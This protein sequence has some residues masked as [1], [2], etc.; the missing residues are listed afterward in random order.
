MKFNIKDLNTDE[1][2]TKSR[3]ESDDIY[4]TPSTRGDRTY[5]EVRQTNLYGLAA[6]QFLI[7]KC[8]FNNDPRSYKDVISPSGLSVEVKVTTVKKVG[9]LLSRCDIERQKP[10]RQFSD[11]LFIFESGWLSGVY[12][13]YGTYHWDGDGFINKPFDWKDE[14]NIA[15]DMSYEELWI[16][17][18]IFN[19]KHNV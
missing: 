6:E 8:G 13:L 12:E 11:W 9:A 18:P 16:Q 7:E 14:A 19:I 10:Y 15:I 2:V 4:S 17:N 5:S 1:L 3:N